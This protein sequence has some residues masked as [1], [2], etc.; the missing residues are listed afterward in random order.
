M[1]LERCTLC[2]PLTVEAYT[3]KIA[4]KRKMAISFSTA[5]LQ[6][7][8]LTANANPLSSD[9]VSLS[10]FRTMSSVG[11]HDTSTIA[12]STL[13]HPINIIDLENGKKSLKIEYLGKLSNSCRDMGQY[14]VYDIRF[15]MGYLT[16]IVLAVIAYVSLFR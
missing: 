10:P 13:D 5:N 2:P 4:A 16:L 9:Y 14:G 8:S 15:M 1:R 7:T 6:P 3:S 12:T 11:N